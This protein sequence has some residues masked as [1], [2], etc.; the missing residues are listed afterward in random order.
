MT[1]HLSDR[2]THMQESATLKMA[3]I[4]RELKAQGLDI[5]DLSIGEPDFDTPQHIKDAAKRAIDQ[6]Y[7]HYTPVPGYPELRKAIA[8]KLKRDNKLDY[9]PEQ[10]VVSTGA[11][12]SI[13]NVVLSLINPG[14]EVLLP[15]PYWVSYSAIADLAEGKSIEIPA[16]LET[17]F[18]VTPAQLEKHITDRTRLIIFSS[19]CNPTGSVYSHDEL[20]ALAQMLT[21]YPN[22]YVICD[23]IYEYINYTGQP[24]TSLASF[25]EIKDRVITV[26]GFSK[27]FAMTGWRLGY[28]AAPVWIA[29]ACDK[30]QGQITS[31]TCSIAQMAGVAAAT[32][33]L[34]PTYDMVAEFRKRRDL[35]YGLLKEIPGIKANLPDGAFYFFFD[36]SSFFGKKAGDTVINSAEDMSGYLLREGQIGL[37][38]GEAFGDPNCIRL[39]YAASEEKLL[40][41][42]SRLKEALAKLA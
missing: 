9:T 18:K 21:K 32:E 4:S 11:K 6:G 30:M 3:K 1:Q 26:N 5:I 24:H 17:N 19:P 10:I 2:I 34:Q 37:V 7:T 38:N 22:V 29:Q 25:P 41:V 12:Q 8:A 42:C 28:I 23:E 27:G 31:G 36:I 33:S 14:D 35:V 39:S 13:A 16:I 20:Q 15:A 40:K